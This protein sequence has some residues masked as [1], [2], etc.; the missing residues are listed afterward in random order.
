MRICIKVIHARED[1]MFKYVLELISMLYN[2]AILW[3]TW[4][5]SYLYYSCVFIYFVMKLDHLVK[6]T[7]LQAYF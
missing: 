7:N 1:S 4:W 2:E 5:V 3:H 6:L